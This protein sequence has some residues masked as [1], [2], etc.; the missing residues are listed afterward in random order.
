MM[1]QVNHSVYPPSF[2]WRGVNFLK[3]LEKGEGLTKSQYLEG[4]AGKGKV[5]HF[6]HKK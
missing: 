4:I 2:C 5:M 6:L 3:N 1:P